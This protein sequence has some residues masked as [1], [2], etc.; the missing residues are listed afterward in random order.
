VLALVATLL[1]LGSVPAR[2]DEPVDATVQADPAAEARRQYNNARKAFEARRYAEAA[3]AFEAAGAYKEHAATLYSAALAWERADQPERA[4]DDFGR[5]LGIPAISP[6]S[7][8]PPGLDADQTAAAKDRLAQLETTLGVLVVR[9]GGTGW[10]VQL[11]ELTEVPVP[12]RLHAAPGTHT[13]FVREPGRP[14]ARRDV[15]LEAAHTAELEVKSE[16][17]PP[18]PPNPNV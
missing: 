3:L 18:S 4:A 10:R 15:S 5:A 11:D 12:A 16:E 13:L 6:A 8:G 14:I 9:G 2:A 7:G 1:E 17:K